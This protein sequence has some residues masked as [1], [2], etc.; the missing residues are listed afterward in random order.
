MN[1]RNL[2]H[3]IGDFFTDYGLEFGRFCT[4][5][6]IAVVSILLGIDFNKDWVAPALWVILIIVIAI[7]FV[8]ECKVFKKSRKISKLEKDIEKQSSKVQ[9]LEATIEKIECV[10]YDLFQYV[11][12][13]LYNK[14]G[15]DGQDR[16]SIYKKEK[17]RF[18]IMSRYSIN[19]QYSSINRS[20]YPISDG[21]I[22]LALQ[23]GDGEYFINNLPEY[24]TGNK[25]RYYSAILENCQMDKEVLRNLKMRSRSFYCLAIKD[26]AETKRNAVIVFES[27]LPDKLQR[28]S[29]LNALDSE[30]HKIVAFVE[31]VRLRLPYIDTDFAQEK[32]F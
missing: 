31:K 16:I 13:S 5:T 28:E 22:G 12:I 15:F 23:N 7:S 26:P 3:K 29:I 10:N 25:E 21:F 2:F 32:G 20:H 24:K 18:V 9:L 8:I 11:L 1:D 14:L 30:K 19:P 17:D 27:T 6:I 4:T